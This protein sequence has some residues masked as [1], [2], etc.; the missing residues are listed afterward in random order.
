MSNINYEVTKVGSN[1]FCLSIAGS[2]TYH[3]KEGIESLRWACEVALMDSDKDFS[4]F[5]EEVT[6]G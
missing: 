6:N 1:E 2:K 4:K 3:T 5:V